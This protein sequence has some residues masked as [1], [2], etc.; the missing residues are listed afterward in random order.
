M[1]KVSSLK[2][3]LGYEYGSIRLENSYAIK[4]YAIAY[5]GKCSTFCMTH[6]VDQTQQ[7]S[8]S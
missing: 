6:N 1:P 2:F 5:A 3:I 8:I 4:S 7:L